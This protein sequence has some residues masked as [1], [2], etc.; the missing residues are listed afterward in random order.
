MEITDIIKK[1]KINALI[2]FNMDYNDSSVYLKDRYPHKSVY[3]YIYSYT[4]SQKKRINQSLLFVDIDI[5]IQSRD[6]S[7][8][9]SS[10]KVKI[11][12]AIM[13]ILNK[14]IIYLHNFDKYFMS[15]DLFYFKNL[16]KKIVLNYH[17]TI[18][19]INGNLSFMIDFVDY[20]FILT[21]NN[22]I[23][24]FDKYELLNFDDII[25]FPP[26]IDFI[27]YVNRNKKILNYYTNINELIKAIYRE[28]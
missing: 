23:Q 19:I 26:I 24:K 18:V 21:D 5:N 27:K 3:D 8:L 16:L 10:E 25:K 9:S 7:T 4:K 15:K 22:K 12:L 17:K 14:E 2:N 13:L 11:E 6:I 20:Y 28:V 1:N